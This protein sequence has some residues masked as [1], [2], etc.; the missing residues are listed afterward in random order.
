MFPVW[1][2]KVYLGDGNDLR[3]PDNLMA[4]L[5]IDEMRQSFKT[6]LIILVANK[7]E[8]EETIYW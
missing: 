7:K 8:L 4:L 5:Q 1:P 2:A 6:K 3:I